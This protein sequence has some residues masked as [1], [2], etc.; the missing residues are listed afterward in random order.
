M[1]APS[2]G[3]GSV[4]A[5][6]DP[7]ASRRAGRRGY[8]ATQPAGPPLAA[9]ESVRTERIHRAVFG[10]AKIV[11]VLEGAAQVETA[12]GIH[13][14]TPGS[15]M[16][17]GA[18][19]WCSVRP[20]PT[21][22]LWTLY[23]DESFLRSHMR[24]V[25]ADT[26][27][28]RPGVHPDAWDGSALVL[29]PG[30]DI[31][32]RIEPL[33]RQISLVNETAPPEVATTRLISL[34]SRAVEIALPTLLAEDGAVPDRFVLPVRGRLAQP[35]IARPVRRS[36]DLLRSRMAEPWTVGRLA[37]EVAVSR[38]HLTRVFTQQ[39]G[40]APMRFLIETR[41]TEFTRLIEETDLPIADASRHVGWNDARVAA[42]WF[43]KRFG[44]TPT[45]YRR[46]P[47]PSCTGA[48][49]CES[50]RGV[51]ALTPVDTVT[52]AVSRDSRRDAH[53]RRLS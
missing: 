7:D 29:H 22:R 21:V 50:C 46:H 14:L 34:F 5:L 49:P 24:W 41:L 16:T 20:A 38:A 32:H 47:H 44:I 9:V 51:C 35:P 8:I 45:Q 6:W 23:F 42:V 30:V 12:T 18:G 31:L 27:R 48:M 10:H 19:M 40:V 39:V 4:P 1:T 26:T 53:I 13:E 11:H 25:L 17:L 2:P 28:V 52:R 15:A 43:R 33:W 37:A 36:V 3:R